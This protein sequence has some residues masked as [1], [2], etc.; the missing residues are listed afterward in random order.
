MIAILERPIILRV[1]DPDHTEMVAAFSP[2]LLAA[3]G[4]SNPIQSTPA[5]VG[6]VS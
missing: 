1:C 2:R 6:V 4:C 5:Q 3:T